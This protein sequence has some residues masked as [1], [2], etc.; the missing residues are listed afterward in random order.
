MIILSAVTKIQSK[1]SEQR[2][3]DL[4]FYFKNF[5]NGFGASIKLID[6][7]RGASPSLNDF[8]K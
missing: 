4:Y 3:S 6:N 8:I 5:G 2:F 1:N 7:F